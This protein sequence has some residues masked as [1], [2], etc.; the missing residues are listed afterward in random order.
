LI[1]VLEKPAN[2]R[3]AKIFSERRTAGQRERASPPLAL[4]KQNFCIAPP[5]EESAAPPR[6]ASR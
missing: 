5:P 1:S 2:A 4:K 6:K 3:Y